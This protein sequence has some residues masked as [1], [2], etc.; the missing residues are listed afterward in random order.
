MNLA[1]DTI[2]QLFHSYPTGTLGHAPEE[3]ERR[4][5]ILGDRE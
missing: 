1:F 5:Q 3:M 2:H 4:V